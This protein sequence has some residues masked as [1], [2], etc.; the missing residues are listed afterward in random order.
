MFNVGLFCS[1]VFLNLF[2]RFYKSTELFL[3]IFNYSLAA[4]ITLDFR[5]IRKFYDNEILF[6][7]FCDI[8]SI[9]SSFCLFVSVSP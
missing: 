7:L 9:S 3:R 2:F 8:N 4:V 1:V 5:F 6:V